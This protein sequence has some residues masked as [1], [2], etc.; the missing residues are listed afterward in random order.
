MFL[1]I[2]LQIKRMGVLAGVWQYLAKDESL[3]PADLGVNDKVPDLA[4]V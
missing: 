3:I 4:H 1:D 2:G